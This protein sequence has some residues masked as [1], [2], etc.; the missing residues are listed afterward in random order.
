MDEHFYQWQEQNLI[1]HIK[2]QSQA[3]KDEIAEI[4]GKHL[5]IRITAP[6]INGNANKH[7][8][9]FLAKTFKVAKS[10]IQL[11]SGESGREKRVLIKSPGQLP[12][13]IMQN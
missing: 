1:L 12:A 2:V 13:M 7:L 5:K 6:P 10:D 9:A 3:S 8:I 11:I 4:L